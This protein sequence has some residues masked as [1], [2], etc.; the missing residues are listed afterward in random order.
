MTHIDTAKDI[1]EKLEPIFRNA[2]IEKA[3]LFGSYAKGSQTPSSDVDIVI[4]S[5]GQL[6]NIH[7]YGVLEDISECLGKKIDL[8]EISEIREGSPIHAALTQE[9]VLLYER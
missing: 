1:K 4:D 6:L 5:R 9:G 2:P 7:F 8:I 3:V